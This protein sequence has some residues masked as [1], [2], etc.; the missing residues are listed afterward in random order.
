[1]AR[2][3]AVGPARRDWGTEGGERWCK[4]VGGGAE[5]SG[6]SSCGS[7]QIFEQVNTVWRAGGEREREGN[8]SPV[9][10]F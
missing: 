1:M 6:V 9:Q 8:Q 7:G 4:P 3:R 2:C 5:G 10:F